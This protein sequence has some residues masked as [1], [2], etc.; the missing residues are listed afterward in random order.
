MPE[1]FSLADR[2]G[3]E[4]IVHIY[5]PA[6]GLRAIVVIDNTALGPAIGGTRMA[7]DVS[8]KEC[9]RLARAMTL[10]NAAA[11][12]PHGGAKSVIFGD[13]AMPRGEKEEIIR[14]FAV[15]IRDLAGYIPGPDM[16]TNEEAMAWIRDEIG[17][18]VGLPRVVG[19]IPLDEIGATGYGLAAAAVAAEAHGGPQV[20]GARV[21]VQGFGAVGQ[22]AARFLAEKGAV[23][24]AASDTHG[25]IADPN[26]LDIGALM[27][28]K[29]GGGAL[30]A[31]AKGRKLDRDAIIGVPCDI[32]IPAARPDVLTADNVGRL[33]TRL[34]LQ[35]AN[36]PATLE[37]EKIL[38]ERGILSIPDFIANAGGVI[39]ASVE[40]HGGSEASA[41]TT[42]A[43][44]IGRNTHEVL[45][46]VRGQGLQ[47]REA[48]GRL[49]E[50]RVAAAMALRR[51]HRPK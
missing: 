25:T 13:P 48:A 33:D 21:A 6:L 16:G 45:A 49:A 24:V 23:L 44:R 3:P 42:I 7:R 51:W 19:G 1:P 28:M 10:K 30:P 20:A 32:W 9:F 8:L 35:G 27:A 14:A 50:R 11:G 4:K 17:R 39:C 31:Y 18:S 12:L 38:H 2:L 34:V 5:E 40:Y 22:H 36:I 41:L 29:A 43:E 15:A 26:G 47:P 46:D 37:A